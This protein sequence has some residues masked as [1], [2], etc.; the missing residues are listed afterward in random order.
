MFLGNVSQQKITALNRGISKRIYKHFGKS[1]PP[2]SEGGSR[3]WNVIFDGA[4]DN[5][6][7]NNGHFYW[8]LHDNLVEALIQKEHTTRRPKWTSNQQS[9]N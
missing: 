7:D 1:V 2:N 9:Q 5:P 3:F 8:R 4:S 6:K